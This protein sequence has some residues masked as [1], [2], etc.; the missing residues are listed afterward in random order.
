[1]SDVRPRFFALLLVVILDSLHTVI[2]AGKES[3]AVLAIVVQ[4]V[5]W[6]QACRYPEPQLT[7]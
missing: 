4:F 1:M 7:K 2:G 6:N 3:V 5:Y